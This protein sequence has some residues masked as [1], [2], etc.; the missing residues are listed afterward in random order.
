MNY[1]F[2]SPVCLVFYYLLPHFF[3]FQV[4]DDSGVF[5]A[6]EILIVLTFF[7]RLFYIF[8]VFLPIS[9]LRLLYSCRGCELILD[10][11]DGSAPTR[12]PRLHFVRAPEPSYLNRLYFDAWPD[13]TLVV[14][15]TITV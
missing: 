9:S 13:F 15:F 2:F 6:V 4:P 5:F 3:I 1:V 7:F 8:L 11:S 14:I 10:I 12:A